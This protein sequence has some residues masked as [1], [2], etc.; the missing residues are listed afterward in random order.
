[1]TLG[2][3]TQQHIIGDDAPADAEVTIETNG[4]QIRPITGLLSCLVDEFKLHVTE[5][6]LRTIHVDPANVGMARFHVHP[7]AFESYALDG[8]AFVAGVFCDSLDKAVQDARKPHK[9]AVGLRLNENRTLVTIER[10][11]PMGTIEWTDRLLNID[12]DAIRKEP[13]EIR[14]EMWDKYGQWQATVE[15]NALHD[16]LTHTNRT[17]DHIEFS[18]ADGRLAAYASTSDDTGPIAEDAD[19][20]E[21]KPNASAIDFGPVAEPVPDDP[22]AGAASF[23]SLDYL[24]D[25]AAGLKAG[26]I[27]ETTLVWGDACPLMLEFERQ[28]EDGNAL[29]EGAFYLAP[30][31]KGDD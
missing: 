5:D 14:D 21:D 20:D 16:A 25:Q 24:I 11:Y 18:E 15:V 26:G 29:V 2:E 13:D 22:V 30:R 23:F 1:M 6:G 8:D 3:F 17:T 12:A 27:C 10:E 19:S 9:D 28:D 4:R 7:A 31:I